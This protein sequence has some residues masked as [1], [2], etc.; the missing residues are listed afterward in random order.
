[1]ASTAAQVTFNSGWSGRTP[2]LVSSNCEFQSL[3]ANTSLGTLSSEALRELESI[4]SIVDY[5]AGSILFLEQE[6]LSQVFVVLAGDVRLS[7]DRKSTRLHS[8]HLRISYAV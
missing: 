8:S 1:M 4:M 7:L 3:A 6:P 2:H 5:R